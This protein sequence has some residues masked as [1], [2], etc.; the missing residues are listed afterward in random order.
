[1]IQRSIAAVRRYKWLI[2][3][4]VLVVSTG[5]FFARKLFPSVYQAE[6]KIWISQQGQAQTGPVR[7]AALL[8]NNSWGDLLA[9][10]TVLGQTV[11][12][13]HLYIQ[14]D[15]PGAG[16]LFATVDVG[17]RVHP[18]EY[19]LS[20]D[21]ASRRVTLSSAT[22]HADSVIER[23]VLG[24]SV[25]RSIGLRWVPDPNLLARLRQVPFTLITPREAALGVR[26]Q[27]S[28]ELPRDGNLMRVYVSGTDG[29]RSAQIVNSLLRHLVATADEFKRRNVTDVRK[30]LDS[31]V[32]YAGSSLQQADDALE[33]F[34]MQTITLPSESGTPINGG[35]AVTRNPV[36]TNYFNLKLS[37]DQLAHQRAALEQTMSDVRAG[38][39]DVQALWQVLPADA[40]TQDIG[41]LLQEYARRQ[42]EL[43]N[44]LLAFTEDHP[45]VKQARASLAQLREHAIPDMVG[46][47]I[48]QLRRREDDLGRQ[49]TTESSSLQQIPPRTIEEAQLTRTVEARAQLY[50]MLRNRFE[51]ARLAELSVEP[52]LSVL[53]SAGMPESPIANRGRQVFFGAI[54]ASLA[55]AIL[56]AI[57]LDQFDKR[58]RYLPQIPGQL[59][60]HII[61]AVPHIEKRRKPD[62]LNAVQIVEA[63]RSLR[64]NVTYTA[65]PDRPLMLTVTSAGTSEGKS[66]VSINLGLAFAE[67]GYRT[68][69]VDGDLRRGSLH[70]AFAVERRP[71]LVDVL[72]GATPLTDAL[73]PTSHTKLLLL[74]SGSRQASAPELLTSESFSQLIQQLRSEFDVVLIDSPP[75][76]AGM[77]P[78]A[79]CVA[80]GNVLFGVR[81]AQTDRD[82]AKQKLDLLSRFPV[83][84]LGAVVND[85]DLSGGLNS[86]YS[87]LP[88]YS[89]SDEDEVVVGTQ[90]QASR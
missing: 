78:H 52:D 2:A 11:R 30:T 12:E 48:A 17:E 90:L 4:I 56:L 44:E 42:S 63:F 88:G 36:I 21:P 74:P 14:S 9:S 25:G 64:L 41:V 37:Y 28:V 81:L 50:G 51:E 85:V 87:Y 26:A 54:F 3:G 10:Y 24:D 46:T 62:P 55:G 18:G 70:S 15:R 73:R 57:L 35:L 58:V 23:G 89:I 32:A 29:W 1:M 84:I 80:T 60:L 43:R 71:G 53:D 13:L 82:F 75:L 33:R 22:G 5:A 8:P 69:L 61:G 45:A 77:D 59:G 38:R 31:Q 27:T 76:A 68:V 16:R 19:I 20:A 49:I 40:A 67:A 86:E 66:L 6:G 65:P 79:L 72:R 39:L 47:L 34:R 83:R 7:A